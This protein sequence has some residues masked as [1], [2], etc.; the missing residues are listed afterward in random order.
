MGKQLKTSQVVVGDRLPGN[1]VIRDDHALDTV[2]EEQRHDAKLVRT[3][4]FS[5][6]T[7]DK[8]MLAAVSY[9]VRLLLNRRTS[10]NVLGISEWKPE[11]HCDV[12]DAHVARQYL[13]LVPGENLVERY[14]ALTQRL[15]DSARFIAVR[16][17]DC[18]FPS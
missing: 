11:T 1:R 9:E 16:R 18:V 7:R 5:Q 15:P 3:E 14:P 10:R 6:F 12:V 4:T 2:I 8:R 13:T 17:S